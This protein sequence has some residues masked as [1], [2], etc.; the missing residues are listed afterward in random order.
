MAVEWSVSRLGRFT[1]GLHW[2]GVIN[3]SQNLYTCLHTSPCVSRNVDTGWY[4]RYVRILT[5]RIHTLK[6]NSRNVTAPECRTR[7][8]GLWRRVALSTA[9]G[10]QHFGG[11]YCHLLHNVPRV[12]LKFFGK[13]KMSLISKTAVAFLMTLNTEQF[14][15]TSGW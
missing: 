2:I 5:L 11:L 8:C 15:C 14:F 13:S 6:N 10:C 3:S 7:S 12:V 9:I 4:C 1:P